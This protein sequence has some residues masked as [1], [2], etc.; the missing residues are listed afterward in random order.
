MPRK[1]FTPAIDEDLLKA[2]KKLAID[3]DRNPNQ[4]IEEGIKYI[5]KKYK[6]KID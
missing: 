2:I 3:L 5:L 6:K 4:L 1:K